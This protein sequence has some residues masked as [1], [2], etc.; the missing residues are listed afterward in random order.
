MKLLLYRIYVI[1]YIYEKIY[2]I[3]SYNNRIVKDNYNEITISKISDISFEV[4]NY[5]VYF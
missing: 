4:Y 5:L 2:K 3:G 1:L